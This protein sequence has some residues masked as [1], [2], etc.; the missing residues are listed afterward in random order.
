MGK[1]IVAHRGGKEFFHE[2]TLKAYEKAI[3]LKCPF[4]E[5]DIR[6]TK[7]KQIVC[8]HD[9]VIQKQKIEDIT[10]KELLNLSGIDVPLFKD[11]LK[12]TKGKIKL[13]CEIKAKG[14][15]KEAASLLKEYFNDDV[16]IVSFLD[17]VLYKIHKLAPEMKTGLIIGK[18]GL[19]NILKDLMLFYRIRK[20]KAEFLMLN[21]NYI[22]F[23]IA[24][25]ANLLKIKVFTWTIDEPS[26]ILKY[27]KNKNI[28]GI[29]TNK[30]K[31]ALRLLSAGSNRK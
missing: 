31:M 10:Y 27:E 14:Y 5:L 4:F 11:T 30:P 3:E 12:L 15:E 13:L 21:Y 28:Y 2:N 26:E 18:N 1:M 25:I 29:I 17:E 20:C 23:G 24:K 8:F 19:F 6:Q 16:I 9:P 7:D 22:K